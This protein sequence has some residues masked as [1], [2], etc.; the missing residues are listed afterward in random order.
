MPSITLARH[1][2]RQPTRDDTCAVPRLREFSYLCVRGALVQE[3]G[4][5]S[6]WCCVAEA[7]GSDSG[8]VAVETERRA[9]PPR[10]DWRRTDQLTVVEF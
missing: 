5:K 3:P 4:L 1:A 8:G 2:T 6:G 10:Q 9:P 7:R